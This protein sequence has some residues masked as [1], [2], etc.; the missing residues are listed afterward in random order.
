MIKLRDLSLRHKLT[1]VILA[2]S[3]LVVLLAGAAFV[4]LDLLHFQATSA[5]DAA[6]LAELVGARVSSPLA[7]GDDGRARTILQ[8]LDAEPRVVTARILTTDGEVVASFERERGASARAT[9]TSE[10]SIVEPLH[11]GGVSVGAVHLTVDQSPYAA[12]LAWLGGVLLLIVLAS[13]LVAFLLGWRLQRIVSNPIER[14]VTTTHIVAEHGDYSVRAERH[15][16]D[17]FGRLI[18]ALN[19]MLAQI[20]ARDGVIV[21]AKE[22]AEAATRAKSDFLANMSHEIRTPLNAIIG[23]TQL[24]VDEDLPAGAH[25][26]LETVQRSAEH[27]LALLGEILD[28]SKIEAGK[29]EVEL[30]DGDLLE[31]IESVVEL[32]KE[33]AVTKGLQICAIL[34]PDL[35]LDVVTDHTR[36][37]QVLTNLVGNAIKFT[38]E[39]EVVIECCV[40]ES[41]DDDVRVRIEVRDTGIG[42]PAD[43]LARIFEPFSQADAS[44]TRKFG[45]TGLGLV[46]SRQLIGLLGGSLEVDSKPYVGSTFWCELEMKRATPRVTASAKPRELAAEVAPRRVLIL[47]PHAASARVLQH[48]LSSFGQ[49]VDVTDRGADALFLMHRAAREGNA[50]ALVIAAIEIT[51]MPIATFMSELHAHHRLAG[52]RVV[53]SSYSN[54]RAHEIASHDAAIWGFLPKPFRL[55][56]VASVFMESLQRKRPPSRMDR[57]RVHERR[58]SRD[59]RQAS[60]PVAGPEAKQPAA[61][62]RRLLVAEDNPINQK[63]ILRTLRKIGYDA[64]VVAN[65]RE[66]VEAV[67]CES[68]ALILMDCQM[69]VMDGYEATAKIRRNQAHG[70]HVPIVAVTANAMRGDRDRCLAAG[71]DD[72]ISKPV[73]PAELDAILQ[74]WLGASRAV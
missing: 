58:V 34:P 53:V 7:H 30:H 74:R 62:T 12:R 66:A 44:T 10:M 11:V 26:D 48:A 69:P 1:L 61:G 37:R 43:A 63:V 20:Q 2:T 4:W 56:L 9:S 40:L 54:P 27:L 6:R 5:R 72:Y 73:R 21:E 42:I 47:E 19:G 18:D 28:F 39:G 50:Y 57:R 29:L 35:P 65:G 70:E 17:D 32:L 31:T 22:R 38:S 49:S 68:F 24:L 46:I 15:G 59:R 41:R 16:A 51:D 8:S 3:S 64:L 55:D 45:G 14:L 13:V 60:A 52:S 23:M 67:L 33:P 36:L 25:R 71:M